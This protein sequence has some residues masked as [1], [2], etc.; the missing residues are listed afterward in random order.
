MPYNAHN[1]NP[2]LRNF[3]HENRRKATKAEACLWKYALKAGQMQGFGFNR[4]RPI[5]RYIVDFVCLSLKLVIEVDGGYHLDP[6]VEKKDKAR[7]KDLEDLEYT[8][9][10]FTNE[11]V[12]NHMNYVRRTI[13]EWIEDNK[14]DVLPRQVKGGK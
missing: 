14:G 9:L 11:E 3:A 5:E 4:Q 8:V 12:L 10:R 7:Q 1:Y 6:E 2:K 13:L